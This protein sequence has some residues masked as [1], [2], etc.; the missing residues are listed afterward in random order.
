MKVFAL[1]TAAFLLPFSMLLG[2]HSPLIDS[3]KVL[4]N[5]ITVVPGQEFKA[6]FF[7][8]PTL[9]FEYERDVDLSSLD[10][11]IITIPFITMAAP[12]V[13][14]SGKTWAVES[15]DKDLYYSLK[16]IKEVFKLFY[17]TISW[18]GDIIAHRVIENKQQKYL[19]KD[20]MALMFSGGVDS[21]SSSL[22]RFYRKQLLITNHGID[23]KF[24]NEK[25]WQNVKAQCEE[26]ARTYGHTNA[27]IKFNF[28]SAFNEAAISKYFEDTGWAWFQHIAHGF[29]LMSPSAPLLF[30][31]GYDKLYV[32]S[33]A[34]VDWPYP[35]GSH[36]LIDNNL[37]FCGISVCHDQDALNRCE[38]VNL[39]EY[40]TQKN[41]LPKPKLR[42]CWFDE[43]GT[44]CLKCEKCLRTIQSM[45]S[46]GLQPKDYGLPISF[47]TLKKRT[48]ECLARKYFDHSVLAEWQNA[49][50]ASKKNL[51]NKSFHEALSKEFI[52]YL[53]WF[54]SL[55]LLEFCDK[56]RIYLEEEQRK[57]FFIGLWQQGST[58]NSDP[59]VAE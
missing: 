19:K 17:P 56:K 33:S 54:A 24:V 43:K 37:K 26:F 14:I 1:I 42:V 32:A 5:K 18:E 47:N 50:I 31:K 44:N 57:P 38:K 23:K 34:T 58:L 15:I 22:G 41:A 7:K 52:S 16:R 10:P 9:T 3:V 27:F 30:L 12:A 45:V 51:Q 48:Q 39:I 35:Y 29:Y 46:Q 13:W 2:A 36:P 49:K 20:E 28:R 11:S 4:K 8:E 6:S 21:T 53:Q 55:N 25:T 40:I 59:F